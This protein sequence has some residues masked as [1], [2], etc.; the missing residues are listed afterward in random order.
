MRYGRPRCRLAYLAVLS[1]VLG[2]CTPQPI[3]VAQHY[4]NTLHP[5][6]GATEY[7]ADL[8]QCRNENSAA[9]VTTVAYYQ[10]YS[11]VRTN[12]V[13][14]GGCMSRHGWEQV[15]NTP[16]WSPPLWPIQYR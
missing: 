2:A 11:A 6:Y 8:T 5:Q 4:L 14:A 1:S 3:P 16:S 13:Q 9:V 7:I 15:A 12:E 10:T